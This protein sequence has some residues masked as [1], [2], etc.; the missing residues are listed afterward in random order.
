[1]NNIS[2][3]SKKSFDSSSINR[4]VIKLRNLEIGLF[5]IIPILILSKSNNLVYRNLLKYF[6]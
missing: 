4:L 6:W 2:S 1:M 5:I 3:D